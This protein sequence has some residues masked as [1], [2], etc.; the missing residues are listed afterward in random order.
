MQLNACVRV[1]QSAQHFGWWMLCFIN[2]FNLLTFI[3]ENI[4]AWGSESWM[5]GC[6]EDI[7][8]WLN[9]RHTHRY[10]FY[11]KC[12]RQETSTTGLTARS[13]NHFAAP[14]KHDKTEI[15]VQLQSL[16]LC[17]WVARFT[18]IFSAMKSLH[19]HLLVWGF[20]WTLSPNIIWPN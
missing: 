8:F 18:E 19:I 20:C 14:D 4:N 10:R 17:V 2:K 3:F 1:T 5:E 15:I 13:Y 6:S 12:V 16:L 7:R 11:I 9:G